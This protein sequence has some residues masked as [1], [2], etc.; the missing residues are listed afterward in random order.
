M[1]F[2][3]PVSILIPL[4]TGLVLLIF[5][6][7]DCR[8]RSFYVLAAMLI[9]SAAVMLGVFKSEAGF[10]IVRFGST[11]SLSLKS[12]GLSKIFASILA[13]LWPV[14]SIYAFEYMLPEQNQSRFFAFWLMS[15]AVCIGIALAQNPLT[16]YFFIE[17]LTLATLPLVMHAGDAKAGFAGRNYLLFSMGGAAVGFIA[18]VYI[19]RLSA[20]ADFVLGGFKLPAGSYELSLYGLIFILGFI[21]F[22]TKGAILPFSR[23]L[24]DAS[25]APTPVTALLHSV[26]VVNAGVFAT[27]RL[28]HYSFSPSLLYGSHAQSFLLFLTGATILYGAFS[29]LRSPHLKRRLAYSTIA[30]LSYMFFAVALLSKNGLI[31]AN[32]HM[33]F[34]A[35]SKI[36]LFFCAGA[37]Y[38]VY[39]RE[40]VYELRDLGSHMPLCILAFSLASLGLICMPPLGNFT[41]K[42]LIGTA[43]METGQLL[44][45]FG[46]FA[47]STSTVL[48]AL[49]LISAFMPAWLPEKDFDEQLSLEKQSGSALMNTAIWA[50]LSIYFVLSVHSNRLIPFIGKLLLG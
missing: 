2:I 4:I 36:V 31:A 12:D 33:I 29:A 1:R 20:G 25:I 23:W 41:S 13:T 39:Y 26:A 42:W 44:S 5:P 37:I 18:L 9:S 14:S 19:I 10:E 40:Y 27:M 24:I 6:I 48:T 16:L 35:Y 34:H 49:Y 32:M 50:S 17:L 21:G 7:K 28:S 15:Y 46:I 45:Y 30:N 8:R 22:G 3:L 43:A 47:L 11:L 38:R